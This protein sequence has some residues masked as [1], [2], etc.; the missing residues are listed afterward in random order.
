MESSAPSDCEMRAVIKFL[1]AEDVT[2]SE[3]YCRLS[4]VYGAGNV[5]F[6]HQVYGCIEHFNVGQ[7]DT[8]D[9]QRT[10]HS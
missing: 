3:I 8:H 2:G 1:N 7:S 9:E 5:M 4:N 10:D 6:L